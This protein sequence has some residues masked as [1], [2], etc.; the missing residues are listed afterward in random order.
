MLLLYNKSAQSART[1]KAPPNSSSNGREDNLTCHYTYI[2][3]R[4]VY[5]QPNVLYIAHRLVFCLMKFQQNY[6]HL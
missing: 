3:T 5:T 1:E 2:Y 4:N 6:T